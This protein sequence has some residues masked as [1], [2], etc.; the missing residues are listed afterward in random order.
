MKI[1][2]L[3]IRVLGHV[4]CTH[5]LIWIIYLRNSDEIVVN[6]WCRLPIRLSST[7][8][9]AW[10]IELNIINGKNK[11]IKAEQMFPRLHYRM[12]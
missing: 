6:V 1:T 5:D 2:L 4:V 7:S 10:Q 12:K 9:F 3:H 8:T 11:T